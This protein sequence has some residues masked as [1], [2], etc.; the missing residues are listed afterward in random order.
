MKSASSFFTATLNAAVA[1]INRNPSGSARGH[2]IAKS[3][4]SRIVT[5]LNQHPSVFAR[6]WRQPRAR[7]DH[8]P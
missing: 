5:P 8:K 1:A 3:D 7:R 6:A 2:G 4:Q